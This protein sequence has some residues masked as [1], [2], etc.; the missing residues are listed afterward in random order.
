MN[1][2]PRNR[3]R[4]R[5]GF[6]LMLTLVTLTIIALL[7]LSCY[8]LSTT[9]FSVSN[10][11]YQ[12]VQATALATAGAQ[13]LYTQ[14]AVALEKG[15]YTGTAAQN[16]VAQTSLSS[17]FGTSATQDGSYSASVISATTSTDSTKSPVTIYTFVIQ[18]VGT[19]ADGFTQSKTQVTFTDTKPY[20]GNDFPNG[21]LVSSGDI[22]LSNKSATRDID[23]LH[24]AGA[25]ANGVISSSDKQYNI[26]GVISVAPGGYSGTVASLG[27]SPNDHPPSGTTAVRQINP[28]MYAFPSTATVSTWQN[29]KIAQAQSTGTWTSTG[30]VGNGTVGMNTTGTTVITGPAY[31]NG[32]LVLGSGTTTLSANSNTSAPNVVYVH[33]N[34]SFSTTSGTLEN[35]G[36]IFVCDGTFTSGN[37]TQYRIYGTTSGN[38]GAGSNPLYA[39]SGLLSLNSSAN[40]VTFSSSVSST[41]GFVY[42]INGGITLNGSADLTGSVT[43]GQGSAGGGVTDSGGRTLWYPA[44]TATNSLNQNFR[45][46]SIPDLLSPAATTTIYV[47]TTLSSSVQT[48]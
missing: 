33:G 31:I 2:Y 34:V 37:S 26:D 19:S 28:S 14:L 30:I 23:T 39:T 42:A 17:T 38:T 3:S 32:D 48:L 5:R 8:S 47:P 44:V 11:A 40:A 27:S 22:R 29:N 35:N 25:W 41:I 15:T 16:T 21:A 46:T 12:K 4:Q 36:V 20:P 10:R 43:S 13:S 9:L 45:T 18:G 7:C 24:D 6:A 1:T